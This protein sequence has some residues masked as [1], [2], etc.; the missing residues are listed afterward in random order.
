MSGDR[1]VVVG[2]NEYLI[3][4]RSTED[5]AA[6]ICE[7]GSNLDGIEKRNRNKCDGEGVEDSPTW[8]LTRCH[9]R[10]S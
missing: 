10:K 3:S 2:A 4:A 8:S 6:E 9:P 5:H 1:E 7:T